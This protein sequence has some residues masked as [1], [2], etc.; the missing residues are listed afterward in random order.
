MIGLT[1]LWLAYYFLH[2]LLA[3]YPVK[4]FFKDLKPR[5]FKFYSTVYNFQSLVLFMLIFWY[6]KQL[7]AEW[8]FIA[9]AWME[10]VGWTIVFVGIVLGYVAFRNYS[11]AEFSG[12]LQARGDGN[13]QETMQITGLN[14]FVRHPIYFASIIILIGWLLQAP[15]EKNGI[16]FSISLIYLFVGA[17]LEEKRLVNEFGNQYLKYQKEVKMMIPFI[18]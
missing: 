10:T 15:S 14:K 8:I 4:G 5:W 1:A 2:S 7:P 18:F 16:F 6:Q 11:F 3:S 9:P 12:Y 13:F 17:W